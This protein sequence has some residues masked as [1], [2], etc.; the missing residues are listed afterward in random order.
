MTV[1]MLG[2]KVGMMRLYD[3]A[4]RVRPVTAIELGPNLVTQIR[5][6]DR[7]G[8]EAV[9]IGHKGNR[10]RVTRPERG[11]LR[12]AGIDEPLTL[13]REMKPDGSDFTLGQELL[14]DQ[15]TPG[16][17]VDVTGT[18]KGKGFA[19]GMKRWNFAGGPASH[20]AKK[21]RGPGSVGAGTSPGK[22]WRGQKMGGHMGARR[23]TVRNLLVV[24]VDVGRNLILVQG[25]VPG[26]NGGLVS[27]QPAVRSPLADYEPPE[28]FAPDEAEVA[29]AVEADETAADAPDEAATG[30]ASTE[31]AETA[32][33][34]TADE[35]AEASDAPAEQ[36][37]DDN[38][39]DGAD[40]DADSDQADESE[41][42]QSD[43]A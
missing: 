32:D 13:L 8:Y 23:K 43:E 12:G 5:T 11:H 28:A 9:Q 33:E 22:T 38:G 26:P 10:K 20:G 42:E 36:S 39:G 17:Y 31:A 16:E 4:G 27:I 24:Q 25:S 21:H 29:P 19:G 37:D 34:T 7:D 30:E 1:G 6:M 2:R 40:T 18:S 3:G 15:Y 14:V 41:K 35:T